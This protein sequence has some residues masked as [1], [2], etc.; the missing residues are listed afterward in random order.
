MKSKERVRTYA[1]VVST[2]KLVIEREVS[3]IS[4]FK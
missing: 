2:A 3:I 4:F 1:E